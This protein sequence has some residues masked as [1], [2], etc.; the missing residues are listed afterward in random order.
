MDQLRSL[1]R[2]TVYKVFQ[3]TQQSRMLI[4]NLTDMERSINQYLVLEDQVFLDTYSK[5]HIKFMEN[6]RALSELTEDKEII[7]VKTKIESTQVDL[8]RR[9]V[10]DNWTKDEKTKSLQGFWKLN[11]LAYDL[12]RS[13][14]KYVGAEAN[15]LDDESQRIITRLLILTGILLVLFIT[16]MVVFAN[17]IIRPMRQLDWAIRSL[18]GGDFDR[19]IR[20]VGPR[21]LEYLGKRLDWLR[22]RLKELEDSKEQFFRDVSHELKT[23]LAKIYEGTNLLVDQVAGELNNEQKEI[24]EIII[25][26]ST[27]LENLITDILQFDKTQSGGKKAKR[28]QIDLKKLVFLVTEEYQ[29]NLRANSL[30]VD[31]HLDQAYIFGN[32][33]GLRTVV[34]NLLSNAIKFSPA[35]STIKV[36]LQNRRDFALLDVEDEGPGIEPAE[37]DKVFKRFYRGKP[38]ADL[39]VKGSGLGLSIVSE[40]V[41][42][43]KGEIE[44]ID[45]KT[46][47][48]GA[49]F[50]VTLP[51]DF[52]R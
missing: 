33:D 17:L 42:T 41:Y 18:G 7:K 4:V 16:L 1:S 29:I 6:L 10:S 8:Y 50:R 15:R 22:K 9:F 49:I 37:R 40:V 30:N 27:H 32:L 19:S 39:G 35:N 36:R 46:G 34:N 47:G 5:N 21:D 48:P 11:A 2:Q 45:K 38:S 23:P 12:L 3:T 25:K 43:H 14:T 26:S 52:R 20:V 51:N 28:E 31:M 44:V 13:S 24:G